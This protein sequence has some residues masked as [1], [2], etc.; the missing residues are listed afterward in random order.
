RIE[1]F[2]GALA[3]AARVDHD[4]V[5]VGRLVGRLEPG[6]LQQAGHALR[7]VNVHLAAER[8]DE[9]FTSH[10]ALS[11]SLFRFRLSTSIRLSP[12]ARAGF[13]SSNVLPASHAPTAE[14]HR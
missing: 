5:G 2:L 7:V 6:L 10:A 14:G 4:D 12:P 13:S 8:F 1:L 11:L 3:D 9:V